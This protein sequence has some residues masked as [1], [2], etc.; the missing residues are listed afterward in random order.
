M[1]VLV[2]VEGLFGCVC[3][4]SRLK[5]LG[6]FLSPPKSC[7]CV[8]SLHD[9]SHHFP[10]QPN[11]LPCL[12]LYVCARR[13]HRHHFFRPALQLDE[14]PDGLGLAYNVKWPLHLVVTQASLDHYNELFRFMLRVKRVGLA[15]QDRCVPSGS[16][17]PSVPRLHLASEGNGLCHGTLS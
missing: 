17:P 6:C 5:V 9:L 11:P 7:L 2:H 15:L 13:R 14:G 10:F 12:V 8:R 16:G 4:A 3:D 1:E